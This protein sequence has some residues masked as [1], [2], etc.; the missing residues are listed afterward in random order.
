MPS[1]ILAASAIFARRVRQ[2]WWTAEPELAAP[3][4][5]PDPAVRGKRVSP[6]STVTAESGTPSRSAAIWARMV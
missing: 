5:P 2:A 6:S 3:Q 4:E 1:P